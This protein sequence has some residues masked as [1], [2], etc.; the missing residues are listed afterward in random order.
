MKNLLLIHLES[1]NYINYRLNRGMFP[2]LYRLE[3][4]GMVFDRYYSTATST[5]MVIG[6]LLYGGMEQYEQ[7]TSMDYIPE[8]YPYTSSLF[9]DLK[10]QG[11]HTSLFV[12]PDGNDRISAEKRHIAGFQNEMILKKK[13]SAFLQALEEGME[14]FP[15]ALMACNYISNLAFNGCTDYSKYDQDMT[16]WEIGYRN[17]DSF[18]KDIMDILERHN[19]CDST[20]VVLYGDHGD[21]YWTHGWHQGRAHGVEPN[22]LLIHTP[23]FVIDFS[24]IKERIT[25]QLITT[26]DL[27][28]MI[29]DIIVN[30]VTLENAIPKHSFVFSRNEYA[31]QP[32]RRESF[33]KAYS[34]S[35][36]HYLLMV[37][38]GGLEL[39]DVYMDSGCHNNL[40]R[41]F[42]FENNY[43][44][45]NA[46][47]QTMIHAQLSDY[48][49]SR[50]KRI[51]R[52]RF[53]VLLEQLYS[54]VLELYE[55]GHLSEEQMKSEM[56]FSNINYG[57]EE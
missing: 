5:L 44:T 52:Q 1:L 43:L 20:L 35:D 15:F 16:P 29:Y 18:V 26:T 45:E 36:G 54:K 6:D 33:N 56:G 19:L 4:S 32:V 40:L 51:L 17:L 7:C 11:Y 30:N 10:S 41:L 47:L 21:D 46:D 57:N 38:A 55:A 9:D 28:K 13:Y 42:I 49:K 37:S 14:H 3:S 25:N 22:E 12:H 23:L 24:S 27:R 48:M 39:Y 31:A 53:Y 8:E 34:V 50:T 2:T